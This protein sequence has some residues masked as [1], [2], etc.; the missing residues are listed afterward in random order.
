MLA[1][2]DKTGGDDDPAARVKPPASSAPP[3]CSRGLLLNALLMTM[4]P[5]GSV[6]AWKRDAT[7][8]NHAMPRFQ[9]RLADAQ[10]QRDCSRQQDVAD[11]VL[12]RQRGFA[13]N[14]RPSFMH[15]VNALAGIGQHLVLRPKVI[16]WQADDGLGHSRPV[17][18][19]AADA[20]VCK[21]P[22]SRR[23]A[24]RGSDQIGF[25]HA[26][27]IAQR[28]QM[29][30][31]HRGQYADLRPD[32]KARQVADVRGGGRAPISAD[33][34]AVLGAHILPDASGNAHG[35]IEALSGCQHGVFLA[36]QRF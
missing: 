22:Q 24:A 4:R 20:V 31:S 14:R 5:S 11:A 34:H 19:A 32:K 10:V 27:D 8:R 2:L 21:T 30:G 36:K 28:F 26:V 13:G 18:Q 3:C 1:Q 23:A 17:V 12:A 25:S 16:P 9:L 35:R 33:K 29:L 15:S 6:S 7:G